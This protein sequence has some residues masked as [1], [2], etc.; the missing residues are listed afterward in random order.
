MSDCLTKM[1]RS[2]NWSALARGSIR[3]RGMQLYGFTFDRLLYLW[4]HKFGLMGRS[5]SHRLREETKPG[6]TVVDVGAN[7]GVY[8]GLFSKSVGPHGKV[9]ALEPSPSNWRALCKAASMNLWNNVELHQ[10]AAADRSGHM[11]FECSVFNSGNNA[12]STDYP[13]GEGLEVEVAPL[14]SIVAGRKVH[15]IKIDV[16]GWEASVLRGARRTLSENRPLSVRVEIWPS[17]LR[18]AGSSADEVVELLESA[19]LQIEAEDKRKLSDSKNSSGYFDI[20][21]RAGSV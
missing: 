19:G 5:D 13:S 8:T 2:F 18:H 12:L 14:D 10:M 16:Q 6:M 4:L 3:I 11:R 20:T 17:G 1:L 21:A 9:I 15:F 7:V